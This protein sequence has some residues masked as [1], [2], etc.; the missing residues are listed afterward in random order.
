MMFLLSCYWFC[1]T[2]E[3]DAFVPRNECESNA[4]GNKAAM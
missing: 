4:A 3:A 2:L 1:T